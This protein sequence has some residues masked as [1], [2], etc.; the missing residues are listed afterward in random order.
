M[1]FTALG[2]SVVSLS[3]D[4]RLLALHEH[5]LKL[6]LQQVVFAYHAFWPSWILVYARC[7]WW[8]GFFIVWFC[9][10]ALWIATRLWFGS[11]FGNPTG[12]LSTFCHVYLLFIMY[13][14]FIFF[15][16]CFLPLCLWLFLPCEII[17]E[18]K[19]NKKIKQ[20]LIELIDHRLSIVSSS[21]S[22]GVQ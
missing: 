21:S 2:K 13:M 11:H 19:W 1:V 15:S 9:L 7:G 16:I 8:Y 20:L 22:R 14:Y 10:A 5:K 17:N 12:V 4:L 6:S 18:M 3:A